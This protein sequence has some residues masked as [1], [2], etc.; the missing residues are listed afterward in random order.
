RV[1][2]AERTANE[3][4]ML[5][6]TKRLTVLKCD[7]TQAVANPEAFNERMTLWTQ[8]MN[9][10][11]VKIIGEAD[12]VQQYD[13]A[14]A[15][16]DALI[17]TQFQIACAGAEVPATKMLGTQPKG[18]NSTGEYEEA[19]YHE[20]L[21]SLQQHDLSP[22]VERHHLLLIRSHVAPKFKMAPFNTEVAWNEL[23]E[24]TAAEQADTELK[25]AQAS[26]HYVEMGAVDGFDVRGKLISDKHSGFNGIDPVVP[27]GPGDR[28]AEM[29]AK[30]AEQ[31]SGSEIDPGEENAVE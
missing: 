11:G 14:L 8:L 10:F 12:E 26:A 24:Q 25:K 6:M 13:T 17:M 5:A 16:L 23:D 2:A 9:N 31:A 18:F 28:D 1:Y 30:A 15:D 29:E 20:M 27:G 22:L 21:A 3:A 19:S 4:P 7:I